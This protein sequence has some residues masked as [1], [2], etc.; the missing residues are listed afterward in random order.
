MHMAWMEGGG[1]R[2]KSTNSGL[3][4]APR[5]CGIWSLTI[6]GNRNVRLIKP[7]NPQSGSRTSI[8]FSRPALRTIVAFLVY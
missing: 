3:C 2:Q 8:D 6:R 1:G 4:P 5:E 7:N